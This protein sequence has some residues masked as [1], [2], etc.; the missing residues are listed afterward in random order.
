[1]VPNNIVNNIMDELNKFDL[2]TNLA[3]CDQAFEE[4]SHQ[5]VEGKVDYLVYPLHLVPIARYKHLKIWA[6]TERIK[7]G[8][9][10]LVLKE[11]CTQDRIPIPENAEIKVADE[12]IGKLL[13]QLRPDLSSIICEHHELIGN[14]KSFSEQF[15]IV[16]LIHVTPEIRQKYKVIE[17]NNR[18]FAHSPGQ[19]SFAFIGR[20]EEVTGNLIRSIHNYLAG[21]LCNNE[22]KLISLIKSNVY[23]HSEENNVGDHLLWIII[24]KDGQLIKSHISQSTRN[25]LV[26]RGVELLNLN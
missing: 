18:E 3:Y 14:V 24:L 4:L 6:L 11:L 9:C 1:M 16:E 15:A 26:E 8:N 22:R 10:I 7:P 17:L 20:K 23:A 19:G 21:R 2:E 5:L 13:V 12:I 25:H